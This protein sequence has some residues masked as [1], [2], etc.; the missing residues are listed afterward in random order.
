MNR[1][2]GSTAGCK[3]FTSAFTHARRV[4]M[5]LAAGIALAALCAAPAGAA[6][7]KWTDANGRVVYSDQPPAGDV[8]VDVIS[9]P[10]PVANPNAV[11]EMVGK[12]AQI[13]KQ[14][15]DAADNAKKAATTRADAE[16]LAGSCRD[17]RAEITK[18]AANQVLLYKVN[19]KGEQVFLDD[20]ER[21]TRR[22]TL[23]NYVKANCP[24]G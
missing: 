9:G 4:V 17:A 21:R 24:R 23:E 18:L 2:L 10:P 8:K 7:Y 12:E 19:E 22:D 5:P 11:K 15:V 20:A 16:K 3:S 6:L 13:K 1:S 14:Q